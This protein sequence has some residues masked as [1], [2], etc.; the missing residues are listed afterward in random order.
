MGRQELVAVVTEAVAPTV[1]PHV[2]AISAVFAKFDVID[3]VGG[4]TFEHYDEFMLRPIEWSPC[5][6]CS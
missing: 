5:R 1:L 3:V 4:A 2:C 6:R